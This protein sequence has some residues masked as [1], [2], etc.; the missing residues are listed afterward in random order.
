[1]KY[2]TLSCLFLSLALF[3]VQANSDCMSLMKA[4]NSQTQSSSQSPFKDM[5]FSANELT[6]VQE[7]WGEQKSKTSETRVRKYLAYV[8]SLS[9]KERPLALRDLA[10]LDQWEANSK[11]IKKFNEMDAKISKKIAAKKIVDPRDQARYTDLYYGCRA[12]RPNEVNKNAAKDFKRFNLSLNLGTLAASYAFYNMDKDFD[13]EWFTKLGYEVGITVLFSYVGG[14]IQTKATDTQIV[15]SLK[16]YFIGRIMGTTDILIYDPLFND[17]DTRGEKVFADLKKLEETNPE[18]KKRI[19][20]LKKNYEER[21]LYRRY[22]DELISKLKQLPHV[23]L[24]LKGDSRDENGLDW[25]NL[26]KADL[27]R[28]EV[29]DILIAAAMAEV[30]QQRKGEWIE[31]SNSGVDRYVF[32]S[33]FYGVQIPKSI[34]QNFITYQILCMGQDNPKLSFTKAVLFNV[35][36]NFAVNQV[37]YGY[38]EKAIN[39]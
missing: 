23:G 19:Q 7:A 34:V 29:Q 33:V 6:I 2:L 3:T 10:Q 17:E 16:S 11:H 37:L 32:N 39:Q 1:M 26:T 15:K 21:G 31:S 8:L 38:R 28:P 36:A 22:K 18:F 9:E 4:F 25:N 12:L 14:N 13:A 30:Y 27:D 20:E 5:D 24:G 35:S